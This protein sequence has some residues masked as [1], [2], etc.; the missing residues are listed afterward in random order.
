VEVL[1]GHTA[2]LGASELLQFSDKSFRRFVF[3]PLEAAQRRPYRLVLLLTVPNS[4]ACGYPPL[5][6]LPHRHTHARAQ[7]TRCI[8]R[9]RRQ[10]TL[11]TFD[12]RVGTPA[13]LRIHPLHTARARTHARAGCCARPSEL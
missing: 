4:P 1:R 9:R 11:L 12:E 6:F 5:A 10:P 2:K 8:R 3:D 13:T 7:G